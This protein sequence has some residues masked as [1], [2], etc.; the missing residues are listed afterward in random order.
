LFSESN[1]RFLCEIPPD[2]AKAFEKTL[3]DVPHGKVGYVTGGPNLRIR[4]AEG[5]TVIDA[6]I[7]QLKKAW[8]KPLAW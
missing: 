7:H 3:A 8:Q 5:N 4:S 6:D 2:R 1:S